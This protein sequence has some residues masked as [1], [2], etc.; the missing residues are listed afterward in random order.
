MIN[1]DEIIIEYFNDYFE[2]DKLINE[3][4]GG[5]WD[6]A[7]LLLNNNAEAK[8]LYDKMEK[9]L[10]DFEQATSSGQLFQV[11]GDFIPFSE[12]LER[13]ANNKFK[14]AN[15]LGLLEHFKDEW[16]RKTE[17]GD[18]EDNGFAAGFNILFSLPN[19]TPDD[20]IRRRFLIRGARISSR[21]PKISKKI[22][23]AF[24][25]VCSCFIYGYFLAA[26]ALARTVLELC[27]KEKY[28]FRDSR[29]CLK[30][31]IDNSWNKIDELKR[32]P[33]LRDKAIKILRTGNE[34]LHDSV[35]EKISTIINELHVR[36]VI[37]DLKHLV[38][39]FYK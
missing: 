17:D 8:I 37:M 29:L 7:D 39:F 38:E 26:A 16:E 10:Y 23:I 22:E 9:S 3:K 2:L 18:V 31:L 24:Q 12:K 21:I 11:N 34:A 19:F 27:L 4:A 15:I 13:L 14:K 28:N 32:N 35:E 1:V 5:D 20:W 6:R 33:H 25:E 36:S 30:E